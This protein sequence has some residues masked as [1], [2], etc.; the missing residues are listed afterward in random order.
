MDAIRKLQAEGYQFN[1]VENEIRYKL[2]DGKPQDPD[3][4]GRL[5][6]E[7]QD[8]KAEAIAFLKGVRTITAFSKVLGRNITLSWTGSNPKV[9]YLDRVP[10]TLDEIERMKQVKN[11][12]LIKNTLQVKEI[13]NGKINKPSR[14]G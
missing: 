14:G 9:V 1:V 7:I 5:L 6:K 13:F 10:Y 4:A 8:H 11:P 2:V 3:K 12:N